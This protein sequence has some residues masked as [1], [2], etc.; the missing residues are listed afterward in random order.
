MNDRTRTE[1]Q[2]GYKAAVDDKPCRQNKTE[3]WMRGFHD[4]LMDLAAGAR[5]DDHPGRK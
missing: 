4:G 3:E 5:V 2:R 1:Y